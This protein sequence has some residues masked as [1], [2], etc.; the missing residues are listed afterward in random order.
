MLVAFLSTHDGQVFVELTP[1]W[2]VLGFAAALAI[3]TC[4]L[5][6][7]APAMQASRTDPGVVMKAGGRGTTAARDRLLLRRALVVSQ[8]ALSLVLLTGALL[9]V[10][11]FRNLLTLNAG[12][13]QDHILVADFD[14]SPLKL[15]AP[16]RWRISESCWLECKASRAYVPRRRPW[17]FP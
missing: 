14:F 6:G 1:D 9:F 11:T 13:E 12:F 4:V 8:V 10:R 16:V 2:R 3:L 5:F 15:P 17:S 7:L